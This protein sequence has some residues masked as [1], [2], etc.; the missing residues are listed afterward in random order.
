MNEFFRIIPEA[1]IQGL[2]EFLP[3]SSSG[4]LVLVDALFGHGGMTLM[5]GAILHLG[6][7]CAVI[8]YYRKEIQSFL[9]GLFQ[10]KQ[11]SWFYF[12][13]LALSTVVTGVF[14]FLFAS[15]AEDAFG[16]LRFVAVMW[17]ITAVILFLTDKRE[18]GV[19]SITPMIALLIGLAQAAAIFPG[20]SRSG[21]TLAAALLLGLKRKEALQYIF[22]ISIPAIAGGALFSL[23]EGMSIEES[24]VLPQ[25]I[26]GALIAGIVGYF[27]IKILVA[28]TRKGTLRYFS[29]Y[30]FILAFFVLLFYN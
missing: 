15:P 1:L 22:F 12:L 14:G 8:A 21:V 29:L 17:L 6:T 25:L 11:E 3:V 9:K 24:L 2:T 4:H 10:G 30:L 20:I 13:C 26:F 18:E 16:S 28:A 27:A 5:T 23:K 7:L 19:R